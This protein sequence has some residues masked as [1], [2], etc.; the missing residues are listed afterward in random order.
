MINRLGVLTAKQKLVLG[1]VRAP[2][3][4]VKNLCMCS[5]GRYH[6]QDYDP[7]IGVGGAHFS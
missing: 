5:D 2:Q 1:D 4:R 6:C 7:K 3:R